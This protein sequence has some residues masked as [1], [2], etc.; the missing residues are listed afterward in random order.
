MPLA[1]ILQAPCVRKND[2]RIM[3]LGQNQQIIDR[4]AASGLD[5]FVELESRAPSFS[6]SLGATMQE[7]GEAQDPRGAAAC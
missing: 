6:E 1:T 4:V 2:R 3:I 7:E 5:T